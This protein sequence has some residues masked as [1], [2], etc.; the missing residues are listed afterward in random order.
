MTI[1]ADT[2]LTHGVTEGVDEEL[3]TSVGRILREAGNEGMALRDV[4]ERLTHD[5]YA[6]P[7]MSRV[8]TQLIRRGNIDLTLDRRLVWVEKPKAQ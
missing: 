6:T 7:R 3:V 1:L 2:Q 4:L 5:G 8:I